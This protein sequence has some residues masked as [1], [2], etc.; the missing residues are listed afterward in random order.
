MK[1]RFICLAFLFYILV[2]LFFKG[3]FKSYCVLSILIHKS[4]NNN[5]GDLLLAVWLH[6]SEESKSRDKSSSREKTRDCMPK[7]PYHL[8][9]QDADLPYQSSDIVSSRIDL[10]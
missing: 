8:C 1:I 2:M 5:R 6:H 9:T 10:I 4:V 7:L 3:D